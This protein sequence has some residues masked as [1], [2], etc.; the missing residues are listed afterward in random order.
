MTGPSS[1]S[2][3]SGRSRSAIGQANRN[4]TSKLRFKRN[5]KAKAAIELAKRALDLEEKLTLM[6]A[7]A[8]SRRRRSDRPRGRR[9][10][11]AK[12][13]RYLRRSSM[14]YG[15]KF[16]AEYRTS[17]F[18]IR[19][20]KDEVR[21]TIQMTYRKTRYVYR[22][23]NVEV[24][25][26]LSAK[27]ILFR[28]GRLSLVARVSLST[29]RFCFPDFLFK[30]FG[31]VISQGQM[32]RLIKNWQCFVDTGVKPKGKRHDMRSTKPAFHLGVWRRYQKIPHITEDSNSEIDNVR[33]ASDAFLTAL[34]NIVASKISTY[35]ENYAP[36]IWKEQ[37]KTALDFES[38]FTTVAVMEGSSDRVHVDAN[39]HGISWILPLGDWEGG[40]LVIPQ[41][42]MEVEVHAGQLPGYFLRPYLLMPACAAQQGEYT[43][44]AA[45]YTAGAYYQ[46]AGGICVDMSNMDKILEI[47]AEYSDLVCQLGARWLD[48][49]VTVTENDVKLNNGSTGIPIFFSYYN[50][51][52]SLYLNLRLTP[53][54]AS[55]ECS[56]P[57]LRA[58]RCP[59]FS[60]TK[61]TKAEWF[62]NG[63]T[64]VADPHRS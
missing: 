43:L 54:P 50:T 56:A 3:S 60:C 55:E 26:P 12:N 19:K 48:V 1:I 15:A 62:L 47:H 41:L 29:L 45:Y 22:S 49:N 53:H 38:A 8:P 35:T 11:D 23:G 4:K 13:R 25:C 31:N 7:K 14:R 21:E 24:K 32:R 20:S 36:R 28:R 63:T 16:N 64:D 17:D 33:E 59:P 42:K 58:V 30:K 39:D 40:R 52:N 6:R 2:V 27:T 37:K 61:T 9:T 46:T 10:T 57:D 44:C 5:K 18:I 51:Y 34:R